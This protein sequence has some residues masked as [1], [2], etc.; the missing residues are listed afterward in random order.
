MSQPR[1]QKQIKRRVV[2]I[3]ADFQHRLLTLNFP[4]IM[5]VENLIIANIAPEAHPLQAQTKNIKRFDS[6]VNYASSIFPNISG[7]V[8]SRL[9]CRPLRRNLSPNSKAF[10]ETSMPIDLIIQGKKTKGYAWGEGPTV[11]FVHG[12]ATHA[13]SWQPYVARLVESGYR[14]VAFDAPAHGHSGGR[15]L[16]PLRYMNVI[17]AFIENIEMPYALV[18]HSYGAMSAVLSLR[19]Q[20]NYP[21]KL[22]LLGSFESVNTIF[23]CCAKH[24]NLS[25]KVQKAVKKYA[26]NM[27]GGEMESFSVSQTIKGFSDAEILIVHDRNDAIAPVNDAYTMANAATNTTLLLTNGLGHKLKHDD[28]VDKVLAFIAK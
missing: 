3:W 27:L 21:S 15:V 5:Y 16:T 26:K 28:V 24:L 1:F 4:F 17:N 18:G 6:V 25:E 22:V 14:V 9:I 12:W 11:L 13:G 8:M 23:S 7:W 20:R 10:L 19:N 2:L